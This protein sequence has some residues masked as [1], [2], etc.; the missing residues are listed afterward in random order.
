MS[1]IPTVSVA[2]TLCTY[3]IC[4]EPPVEGGFCA[5]H[6]DEGQ[7]YRQRIRL[8]RC[9]SQRRTLLETIGLPSRYWGA[10][11]DTLQSTAS[12]RR[13]AGYRDRRDVAIGRSMV[14]AGP[15]GVGKT[16]AVAALI[17][18]LLPFLQTAQRFHVTATLVR[19]LL[20]YRKGD[21]AMEHATHVRL[22]VL[23]DLQVP[24]RPEGVA[25]LEELLCR[26]EADRLPLLITTNLPK[27]EFELSFSDRLVDRVRAW[28][29]YFELPGRS[30]RG[31]AS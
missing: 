18:C 12:V 3:P 11:F 4:A 8:E 17:N 13:V 28:G 23:D 27:V 6:Q 16:T 24:S 22:L 10:T 26:R 19:D 15:T 29:P 5:R 1:D 30:L 9:Q 31:P 2:S 14:L 21:E 7:G 25:V 20:D